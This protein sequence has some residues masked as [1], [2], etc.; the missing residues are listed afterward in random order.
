MSRINIYR[1][2]L[3][4]LELDGHIP[5]AAAL[6]CPQDDVIQAITQVEEEFNASLLVCRK[7]GA[8]LTSEGKLL[9]PR[10][11]AKAEA[12]DGSGEEERA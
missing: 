8:W 1:A 7:T 12:T 4:T 5:A 3:L 11:L 9:L 6:G 10:I 2:F